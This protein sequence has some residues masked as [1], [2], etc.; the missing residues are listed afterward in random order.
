MYIMEVLVSPQGKRVREQTVVYLTDRDRELLEKLVSS[1]GLSRTELFRRG[2]WALAAQFGTRDAPSAFEQL[3]AGA[4]GFNA[5]ADYAERADDYLYGGKP[6]LTRVAESAGT[7]AASQ[8]TA[9]QPPK[10]RG[11][12]ARPR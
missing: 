5:P 12:R 9:K 2:L 4:H 3:I 11:K 1:T 8:P 6:V 10:K 7:D